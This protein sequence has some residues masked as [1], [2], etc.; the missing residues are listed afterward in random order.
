MSELSPIESNNNLTDISYELKLPDISSDVFETQVA[1]AE[2]GNKPGIV[3]RVLSIGKRAVV[4]TAVAIEINPLTNGPLRY[5]AFAATLKTT[6]NVPLSVAVLAGTTAVVEGGG[7]L[8]MGDV[9]ERGTSKTLNIFDKGVDKIVSKGQRVSP[10]AEAVI[11]NYAGVP[12]LMYAKKRE[13][14]EISTAENRKHA[15]KV[16]SV[17][18]G[19]CAIQG[20]VIAEGLTDPTNPKI[21][22]PIV[23]GAAAVVSAGKWAKNKIKQQNEVS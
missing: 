6:G 21:M 19:A 8:A 7:A 9:L 23:A 18:V 2:D 17:L 1:L 11:T 5:G 15:L 12:A 20:V 14:T 10:L 3:N 4:N 16:T 13:N 22:I